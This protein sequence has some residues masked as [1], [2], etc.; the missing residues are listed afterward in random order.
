MLISMILNHILRERRGKKH[1]RN[2]II[3]RGEHNMTKESLTEKA[4]SIMRIAKQDL[5]KDGFLVPAT[6]L[7]C[8]NKNFVVPGVFHDTHEKEAYYN[9]IREMIIELNALGTIF[10]SEIW[11]GGKDSHL[12]PAQDPNRREA[13]L[14]TASM[15]SCCLQIVQPYSRLGEKIL[16]GDEMMFELEEGQGTAHSK[17]FV[18]VWDDD[19]NFDESKLP[20]N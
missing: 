12:T 8:D 10:I 6:F 20:L 14:L 2:L 5:K 1:T 7:L 13:L 19:S 3:K 15:P 9:V 4:M 11:V 17:T 18:E 16:F